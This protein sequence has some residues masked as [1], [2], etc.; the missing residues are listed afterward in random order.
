MFIYVRLCVCVSEGEEE[1]IRSVRDT[2]RN[3]SV[4]PM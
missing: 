1:L 3:L 2:L 4:I